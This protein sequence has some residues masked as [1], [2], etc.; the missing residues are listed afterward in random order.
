MQDVHQRVGQG[1]AQLAQLGGQAGEAHARVGGEGQP[2]VVPVA[3][4]RRLQ[5]RVEGVR[6]RDH[7]GRV[8]SLDG[9]GEAAVRVVAALHARVRHEEPGTPPQQGEV[10]RA[11]TPA[12]TGQQAHQGGVGAGVLED[13]ADGDEVGDLGQVQ[14]SG[15]ADDLDRDVPGDQGALDLGEIGRRAAQDGDLAG[16][17]PGPYEVGDGVG[18]P[19]DLL[20]VGAQQGAADHAVAFGAGGRAQ[21]LHARVQGPQGLREAVREVEET[22][23]AAAVLAERLPGR[24]AAVGVG[25]VLG[26]VVQVGD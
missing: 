25:E 20:G 16:C 10:A 23:A 6:E 1:A 3:V 18:G 15:Q 22:A 21:G 13:L 24:R 14:Q 17:R 5:E 11:D 4:Q 12:G 8:D 2:V 7:L 19:V 26:E 9:L